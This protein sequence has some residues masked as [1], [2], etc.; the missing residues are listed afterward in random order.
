MDI[1]FI[2]F[3][4][5][6]AAFADGWQNSPLRPAGITAYDRKTDAVAT[7]AGKR[8][9]YARHQV[10]GCDTLEE[11]LRDAALIIS[12]V[13]A[14]EALAAARQAAAYLRA[15]ALYLDFNSVAPETKRAACKAIEAAGGF[16]ADVAVMS[17]VLPA[18]LN[19]PLLVSGPHASAVRDK[20]A[21]LGFTT[22]NV[23]GPVGTASSI[24]MIRSVM[25]KGLEA[26]TAEC[27]LSARAAGV[28]AEVLA[29]LQESY[30]TFDWP[31]RADY[32]LDR[33]I[34]HGTRRAAEMMEAARTVAALGQ[35]GAMAH[36]TAQWQARIGAL[37]LVP[38]MDMDG[39]IDSILRAFSI[40]EERP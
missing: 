35:T 25:V 16:Y 14:D 20:L 10:Q 38:P 37:G 24:K 27:F 2:G 3:G 36:A 12:T 21:K 32:N 11:A 9:D 13:T 7:R 8:E 34:V 29:S 28:E 40:T 1:T 18:R 4:E 17:P 30:P 33:M 6:A 22:R 26:L 19:V 39:K 31:K 5:A 15:G 23:G